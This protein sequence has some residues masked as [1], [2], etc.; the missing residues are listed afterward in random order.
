MSTEQSQQETNNVENERVTRSRKRGFTALAAAIV[1]AAAGYGSYWYFYASRYVS[2]DNAYAEAEVAAVTPAVGGIVAKVNVVDTQFV[3]KGDVLV[4]ID[5]TDAQIALD[6][7]AADLAL[8]KR[9]VQSYLANNDGLTA[10]VDA[11]EENAKRADAQLQASKAD[12]ERATIDLKRREDL[13]RSGSVSGEELTNAQTAFE[14]AKANL[15][16]AKAASAQAHA[17]KLSTLGQKEANE[18]LIANTTVENNPEV[19][20]AKARFE[21][22]QVDFNRT[23]IRSPIDGV[24]AER[25][26]QI[27]RRVN[28]GESLMTVVPVQNIYVDANFKEVQLNKVNVGQ[29]VELVADLYGD[30]VVYHGVVTGLSGGT[31]SAFSMIPAQNATGNWIK[32]VQ[33][34]PV[35]IQLNRA[36]LKDH[37]LQ[38]GLSMEV[39][40]DTSRKV[41]DETLQHYRTAM[42][43]E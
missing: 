10:L 5:N 33:R 24:V 22:A 43:A 2:T 6:R 19:L 25:R 7:A 34:L 41:D 29:P 28:I 31:G 40:I 35:R 20:A 15:D 14:Q 4:N 9:H 11:Q 32:V 23:V 18:A 37:P 36:E 12:F 16:A 42:L 39:T 21:Q 26:V 13:V 38:V 30:D 1:I 17:S 8:A 27:G 3:H